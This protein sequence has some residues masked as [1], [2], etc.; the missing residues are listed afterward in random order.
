MMIDVRNEVIKVTGG[1]QRPFESASLTGQFF[2]KPAAPRTTDTSSDTAAELAS[3]REEIGRL[4]AD[5]GALL[6]SQQEQL[7]LLQNKLAEETKAAEQAAPKP[8]PSAPSSEARVIAVEPRRARFGAG[9]R[10][11][12]RTLT[13]ASILAPRGKHQDRCRRQQGYRGES[14][15]GRQ[16]ARAV[17]AGRHLPRRARARH[18]ERAQAARMLFWQRE[19]QLERPFTTCSRSFQSHRGPRPAAGG[20]TAGKPRCAKRLEG[21]PLP[22][23]ESGRSAPQIA[24]PGRLGA[25]QAIAASRSPTTSRGG[26][27]AAPKT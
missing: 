7:A 11:G 22:H 24:P 12:I 16:A 4:Q 8:S 3:L 27:R 23:R 1:K 26:L 5:Q 19:G 18:A 13:T 15:R 6:K 9:E 2:F 10:C 21:S 20:A 14:A 17:L 25:A